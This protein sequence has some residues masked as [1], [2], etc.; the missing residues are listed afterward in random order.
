[1][2]INGSWTAL[3][4]YPGFVSAEQMQAILDFLE[5]L[6]AGLGTGVEGSYSSVKDRLAAIEA[7]IPPIAVVTGASKLDRALPASALPLALLTGAHDIDLSMSDVL[8]P[9][10]DVTGG[11]TSFTLTDAGYYVIEA[12][13]TTNQGAGGNCAL[14]WYSGATPHWG[15]TLQT[16]PWSVATVA[17]GVFLAAG[18]VVKCSFSTTVNNAGTAVT[19]GFFRV[20]PVSVA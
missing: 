9:D 6:S 10:N 15:P 11:P 12:G 1:M 2:A 14:G 20:R 8:S 3:E 5:E 18:T 17:N 19:S 4:S 7:R 16:G 13:L